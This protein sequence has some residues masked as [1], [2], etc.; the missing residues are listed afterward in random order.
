MFYS[1]INIIIKLRLYLKTQKDHLKG[2]LFK[3]HN[4]GEGSRTPVRRQRYISFYGCS[5]RFDVTLG[6]P[7]HRIPFGS[8]WLSYSAHLRRRCDSVAHY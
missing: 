1:I 3:I 8:A 5:D 6:T 2:G 7:C 4:G